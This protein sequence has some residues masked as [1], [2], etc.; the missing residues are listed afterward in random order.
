M[1]NDVFHINTLNFKSSFKSPVV[2]DITT[3]STN[4]TNYEND[5]AQIA[6]REMFTTSSPT[7]I[8]SSSSSLANSVNIYLTNNVLSSSNSTSSS[9]SSSSSLSCSLQKHKSELVSSIKLNPVKISDFVVNKVVPLNTQNY[10]YLNR[11]HGTNYFKQN[12]FF[13]FLLSFFILSLLFFRL[14][15]V[16]LRNFL[17]LLF[18]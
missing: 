17:I 2:I 9:S 12:R 14:L 18:I 11:Q 1:V 15:E 5:L 3:D 8:L 13:V 4:S 6:K 7:S 16:V 10:L